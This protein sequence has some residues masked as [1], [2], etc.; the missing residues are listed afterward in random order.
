VLL[1]AAEEARELAPTLSYPSVIKVTEGLWGAGVTRVDSETSFRSV[2][3]AFLSLGHPLLIQPYLLT[4]R[5]QQ[6]RVLVL[7]QEI[8][9]AY[10]T[11]PTDGDFR[12]NLHAGATPTPVPVADT[13][14][15]IAV[16]SAGTLGLDFAGVDLIVNDDGAYVIEVNP[17]PG[18]EYART[19]PGS[20]I[21]R[22]L[23]EYLER[24]VAQRGE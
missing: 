23:V 16:A 10:E 2:S 6:L 14:A 1:A 24:A 22:S 19:I 4:E 3:E 13:I 7:G 11:R 5:A 9:A 15:D 21:G 12:G 18:F 20:D 8:L 17:A